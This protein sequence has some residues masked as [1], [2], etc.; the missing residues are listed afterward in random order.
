M[1]PMMRF[2]RY[3]VFLI[4]AILI[5]ILLVRLTHRRNWPQYPQSGITSPK[6]KG[7]DAALARPPGKPQWTHRPAV[8]EGERLIGL[9]QNKPE[10]HEPEAVPKTTS[11]LARDTKTTTKSSAAA[12]ETVPKV[13]LPDRKRPAP[14]AD[15]YSGDIYDTDVDD[16]HP[17]APP[18]RQEL[19]DMPETT[20]VIHWQKQ[21]EHFPVPTESIIKLPTGK[22]VAI[23]KIQHV[24]DDETSDA[25]RTREKRQTLVREEFKKAWGGY[26]K[27]AWLHD[28]L[29][30]VSGKFRDPFCG[31]AA[32]LVD[33]LDTL[34]IMGLEE[35]FEEAAKAV[36]LIDFNTSP[37]SDIPMFETTIR[38]LGGLLDHCH[39]S[40]QGWH[41]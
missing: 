24:F 1:M 31:W 30:P 6:G 41:N 11:N 28:E 32:T 33:T 3:R 26:K 22:P 8:E 34:W 16:I 27:Y 21:V 14:V 19:V 37:R 15:V 7:D 18:G 2:R 10:Q 9:E 17:I 36:S 29:S 38:Y 20:S 13:I 25:K 35:E 39:W 23:P 4:F 40:L 12:Q 5:T